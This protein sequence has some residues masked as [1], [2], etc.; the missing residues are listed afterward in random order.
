MKPLINR[1]KQREDPEYREWRKFD[2]HDKIIFRVYKRKGY[3][4]YHIVAKNGISQSGSF[5]KPVTEENI[6]D[7][8]KV[9]SNPKVDVIKSYLTC[10]NPKDRRI[11][12]VVGRSY[13]VF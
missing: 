6:K 13:S 8:I 3:G 7:F 9:L 1:K 11:E 12:H 2:K 4:A 5:S 10:W